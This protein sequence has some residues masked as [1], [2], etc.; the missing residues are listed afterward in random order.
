MIILTKL[1]ERNNNNIKIKREL[2]LYEYF[3]VLLIFLKF[4][5]LWEK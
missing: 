1:Y 3:R 2:T 4:F 5:R